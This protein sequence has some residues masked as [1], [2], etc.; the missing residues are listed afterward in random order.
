MTIRNCIRKFFILFSL[1]FVW[2]T[3]AE[4]QKF[5][6]LS[7][8][9]TI[10]L[11]I[12]S[13]PENLNAAITLTQIPTKFYRNKD[14]TSSGDITIKW[15]QNG[16][17][18]DFYFSRFPN[19]ASGQY[20]VKI[21]EDDFSTDNEITINVGK[22]SITTGIYYCIIVN[23][24]TPD[25]SS[26]EFNM[27]IEHNLS[28]DTFSPNSDTSTTTTGNLSWNA[29]SPYTPFYHIIVSNRPLRLE[30]TN[31]DG[32]DEVIGINVIY[33][34]IT[35][36]LT[37]TYLD[38]DPSGF[39]DNTKSPRLASG[40]K[41][42]WLIF[43]NY[44]N[45][46]ALTSSVT[47]YSEA[48]RFIYSNPST[49][50][51]APQ[52]I[53]PVS[54]GLTNFDDLV[55]RWTSVPGSNYHLYLYEE[56]EERGSIGSF[57]MY[58][59]TIVTGDTS[60]IMQ[61]APQI[62]AEKNYYWNVTAEKGA[63]FSA[64]KVDSFS[65]SN[66]NSSKL[67]IRTKLGI[68]GNPSLARVN[69]YIQ[70]VGGPPSPITF[71]TDESG[72]LQR[73]MIGGNYRIIA[74]KDGFQRL[75]TLITIAPNDTMDLALILN[76]NPTYFS[77]IIQIP[78]RTV[79]PQMKI[80][81]PTLGDTFSVF[82][83]LRFSGT[84]SEYTFRANVEPGE[85]M[86]YPFANG[87]KAVKGDTAD[88]TIQFGEYLTTQ[89]FD[90]EKI[91]SQIIVNVTDINLQP[92]P[93]FKITFTKGSV[94][95]TVQVNTLPYY[96]PADPGT[97][98]IKIKK[99]DYFSQL[100]QYEV[101]VV[102]GQNSNLDIILIE[103]GNV[104]GIVRDDFGNPV[105]TARI[106]AY[107]QNGL[108]K[109]AETT[110]GII[111]EY[112]PL[113]LK[114]GDYQL[115]VQKEGFSTADTFFTISSNQTIYYDPVLVENKSYVTG[116]VTDPTGTLLTGA[117]VNYLFEYGG[118]ISPATDS[119]GS[120]LM[121]VP[122]DVP[123][124][125]FAT[126]SG[127][128]T[129]DTIELTVSLN[130][131]VVQNF[132]LTKLNSVVTG[133]VRTIA[134]SQLI[135]VKN[136]M[137]SII[138]TLSNQLVYRDTANQS[139][140]YK[141]YADAGTFWLRAS[142]ENY[143]SKQNAIS[144]GNDDSVNVNFI[145]DKN[146]GSVSGTVYTATGDPYPGVIVVAD[147]TNG[148]AFPD[149]TGIDGIFH[150]S[151]L[152]PNET[153]TFKSNKI[154]HRTTPLDGYT[155]KVKPGIDTSNFDFTLSQVQ[156]TSLKI[157]PEK[158]KSLPNDQTTQFFYEAKV[159][160]ETITIEPPVWRIDYPDTLIYR[161]ANFSTTTNG[162]FEPESNVLDT[163]F[164]ISIEDTVSGMS[165]TK[166]DFSIYSILTRDMFSGNSVEIMD[167]TGLVLRIDSMDIDKQSGIKIYLNRD[168]IPE[169]KAISS[170]AESYGDSYILSTDES[171]FLHNI[172]LTLPIPSEIGATGIEK[173]KEG[174]NLGKWNPNFLEWNILKNS[175]IQTL[176]YYKVS[177]DIDGDGE[178]I[179]L[180]TSQPLGIH[181]LKIL[182][183][184]FS[185]NLVNF[186]DPF[187]RGLNGQ[188]IAFDLT[189]LDIRKPFVTLKIYNMNGQLVR[190]LAEQE[191]MVKGQQAIVWDGRT[192]SGV[193]ARNGRYIVHLKVKDSTGEKE[194]IKMSVLIK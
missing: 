133:L 104:R 170:D 172:V 79:V 165:F 1:L 67:N 53:E 15:E 56:N 136:A 120:Y 49:Y 19:V 32:D 140:F 58:D 181:N 26:I 175:N 97:W 34:S 33:Q 13:S 151:D 55:F 80:L 107:P 74:S 126:K 76:N 123:I 114:P 22:D 31:G 129:S 86:L 25:S 184:P 88:T 36:D 82:G 92:I 164:S 51:P 3:P 131:T 2:F 127:Y 91:P 46:P 186:N 43:N 190:N 163:K 113:I 152:E 150:F 65:Y 134:L 135:P 45:N 146:Y 128:A 6:L 144:L 5:F 161:T 106:E 188:T 39:F 35:S 78:S 28:A 17:F 61:I 189:S 159:D 178:Y 176:P 57:L 141:V 160:T 40:N 148:A 115:I 8:E 89:I 116:I 42:Y 50:Q 99:D 66:S 48:P 187:N 47:S 12:L 27:V 87:F 4:A 21:I 194:E 29:S 125:V 14:T 124:K 94:Q 68:P 59:T 69:V 110:S 149:T 182:P 130:Q 38:A 30:D 157:L 119:T 64:S 10:N 60:F 93:N 111:G 44:G 109:F 72:K 137:V 166:S 23:N 174:I 191:P 132:S 18:G 101:V 185:P 153:Y 117:R 192:N 179:V 95:Q 122:S 11:E 105:T 63:R 85:W 173:N 20:Q 102:D 142:H 37:L 118:G 183:N 156:I 100:D 41:Y 171:E 73:E 169:S 108:G 9:Q 121:S 145:L 90:L 98:I 154:R 139:G 168:D 71:L 96:H 158:L 84:T 155:Y 24:L 54:T 16:I 52:N 83:N 177:N 162:L 103:G 193:M 138:D 180:I 167:H 70:L 81:S 112:G 7:G 147:P 143:I 77:G 62:M 75:D